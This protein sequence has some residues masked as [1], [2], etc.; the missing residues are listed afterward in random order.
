MSNLTV[1]KTTAQDE[2]VA[3]HAALVKRIAY[4]LLSHLPSC[5]QMEDLIQVGMMGL[6]DAS[7]DYDTSQGASFKTYA[8]I[9]IRGSMLDGIR[10]DD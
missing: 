7:C 4:H 1:Y 10:K 8:G 9:R 6:L 2:L 5:V 3:E